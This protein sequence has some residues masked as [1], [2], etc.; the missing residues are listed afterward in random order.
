MQLYLS[1]QQKKNECGG[2]IAYI[3][4]QKAKDS[5]TAKPAWHQFIVKNAHYLQRIPYY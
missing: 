2:I 4:K 3:E 1:Q 5:D